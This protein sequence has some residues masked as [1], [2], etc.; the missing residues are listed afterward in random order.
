MTILYLAVVVGLLFAWVA[1]D[2]GEAISKAAGDVSWW[3]SK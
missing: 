2:G 1:C 3:R